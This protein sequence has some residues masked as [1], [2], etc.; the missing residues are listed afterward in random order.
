LE[1]AIRG[2]QVVESYHARVFCAGPLEPNS[3]TTLNQL[4][5]YETNISNQFQSARFPEFSVNGL[6]LPS[7]CRREVEFVCRSSG[8]EVARVPQI[9]QR[10]L[11][12]RSKPGL[13][14][15]VFNIHSDHWLLSVADYFDYRC[16]DSHG[17][18]LLTGRTSQSG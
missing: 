10:I 2:T 14:C 13:Y 7:D 11:R 4:E 5:I 6:F 17:Q 9:K 18:E 3:G 1:P 15:R 16:R 12:R 8:N